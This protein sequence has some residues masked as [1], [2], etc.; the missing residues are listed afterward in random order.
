MRIVVKV[1]A[2]KASREFK[3]A[4][5]E[6]N[7][8]LKDALLEAGE[9][10]AL[11]RAKRSAAGLRVEGIPIASTLVVRAR[12]SSAYIT[13]TL[14]GKKARAVGYLEYGGTIRTV[15]RPKKAKALM[16][17]F[18]PRAVVRA[19]RHHRG[20]YPI[21]RAVKGREPLIAAAVLEDVMQAFN[22]LDHTP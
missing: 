7:Q 22:G 2:D 20:T 14:R 16:T 8:R 13:S 15:I 21:T 5:R 17:P 3:E 19:P 6:I 18:G 9:Q 10:I 12:R 11:P 4:R 1:D